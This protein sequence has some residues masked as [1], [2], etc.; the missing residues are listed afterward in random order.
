MIEWYARTH[1]GLLLLVEGGR[2]GVHG[3]AGVQH[4]HSTVGA[5]TLLQRRP[6][7]AAICRCY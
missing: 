3:W 4:L 7:W 6:W 2:G 1:M 5:G